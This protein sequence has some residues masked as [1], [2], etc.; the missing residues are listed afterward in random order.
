[1][2]DRVAIHIP[3]STWNEG[4]AF[5]A[6]AYFRDGA[7]ADVPGT[8]HYRIDC[9]TACRTV[10]DWTAVSAAVAV[11]I[12]ITSPDNAI[13]CDGNRR[14]TKQL[15]VVANKDTDAQSVGVTRWIVENLKG[16]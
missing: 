9:L 5:T 2:P 3:R 12:V 1:M 15:T 7:N 11:E 13:L 14:E 16:L 6:E 8:V 10:R 4:S